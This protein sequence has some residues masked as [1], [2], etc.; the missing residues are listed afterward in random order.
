MSVSL[1]NE[2]PRANYKIILLYIV[3]IVILHGLILRWYHLHNVNAIIA[4]TPLAEQD[5]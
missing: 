4:L 3:I 1:Q 2:L 5:L